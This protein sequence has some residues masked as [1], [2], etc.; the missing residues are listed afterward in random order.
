M[1]PVKQTKFGKNSGNCLPACLASILETEIHDGFDDIN[2][3]D[4]LPAV[5]DY[6]SEKHQLQLILIDRGMISEVFFASTSKPV[7]H[8]IIVKNKGVGDGD[9][10]CVVGHGGIIE[11]DPSGAHGAGYVEDWAVYG[12]LV[13]EL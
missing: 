9:L 1:I 13:A 3:N 11:F 6:L 10:H 5:N 2:S 8:L 7:H 12:F 4:W